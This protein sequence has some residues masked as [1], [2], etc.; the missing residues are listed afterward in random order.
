MR[1]FAN[2]IRLLAFDWSNIWKVVLNK[3]N[4]NYSSLSKGTVYIK[5][6]TKKS[7]MKTFQSATRDL[8]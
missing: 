6:R 2:F 8:S 1:V 7:F 3:Q 4:A 5:R